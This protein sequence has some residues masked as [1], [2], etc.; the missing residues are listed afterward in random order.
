L[1]LTM[2]AELACGAHHSEAADEL[3]LIV[4]DER[5]LLSLLWAPE[6]T[7]VVR[8]EIDAFIKT[9]NTRAARAIIQRQHFLVA[10]HFRYRTHRQAIMGRPVTLLR[11]HFSKAIIPHDVMADLPSHFIC[12]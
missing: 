4:P 5:A 2:H 11:R 8:A 6:L 12:S 9:M 1:V 10:R 7:T 3:F